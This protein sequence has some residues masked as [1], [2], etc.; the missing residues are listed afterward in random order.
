MMFPAIS[1]K[2]LP[3][4]R[5]VKSA[6]DTLYFLYRYKNNFS[7]DEITFQAYSIK[8]NI[9]YL[10]PLDMYIFET[11]IC[12]KFQTTRVIIYRYNELCFMSLMFARVSICILVCIINQRMTV[13]LNISTNLSQPLYFEDKSKRFIRKILILLT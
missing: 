4:K 2:F 3:M 7:F 12:Y 6:D 1:E 5:L 11:C 10:F 9:S 13:R 8:Y